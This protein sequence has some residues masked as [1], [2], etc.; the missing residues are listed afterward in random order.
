MSCEAIPEVDANWPNE[1]D[2]L[3]EKMP[4][5]DIRLRI[6]KCR[7]GH[8][9][10]SHGKNGICLQLSRLVGRIGAP[11]SA[12]PFRTQAIADPGV[13]FLRLKRRCRRYD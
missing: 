10:I 4:A 8:F 6:L 11:L 12:S 3:F 2:I 1:N 13:V 7:P 9:D 5:W